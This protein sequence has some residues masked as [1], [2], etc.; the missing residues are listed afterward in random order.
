MLNVLE[1]LEGKRS[2][3]HLEHLQTRR[4]PSQLGALTLR[5][6]GLALAFGALLCLW[7]LTEPLTQG[8]QLRHFRP[9]QLVVPVRQIID[10]LI[11]PFLL[12]LRRRLQHATSDYVLKHLVSRLL[13]RRRQ[14]DVPLPVSVSSHVFAMN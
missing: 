1:V 8:P 11:E 7:R 5:C 13:E 4:A 2:L 3:E 14:R 10:R 9:A 12:V 6:V